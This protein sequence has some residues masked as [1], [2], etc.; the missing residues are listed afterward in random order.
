[1]TMTPDHYLDHRQSGWKLYE[2]QGKIKYDE[3]ARVI[4]VDDDLR[5]VV[6]TLST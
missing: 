6:W 1:M 2:T 5:M 3:F 4:T